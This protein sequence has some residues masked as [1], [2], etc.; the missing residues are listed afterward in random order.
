MS[1]LR[2]IQ[3]AA[4]TSNVPISNLLRKC[5]ILAS[6]L[7]YTN[8]AEWVDEELGGYSDIDRLPEYRILRVNSKGHFFGAFGQELKNADIPLLAIDEKFREDLQYSYLMQPVIALEVLAGDSESGVVH[9]AWPPDLVAYVGKD[10]YE[11]M[12]C[13]QAWKVIPVVAIISAI[14]QVRNRVLNFVL[15]I[16]SRAPD[17]GESE[18]GQRPIPKKE[19]DKIFNTYIRR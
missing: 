7:D 8:L 5:K 3:S 16:E 1:L 18:S 2:E 9:E 4:T 10:I 6:R 19:V 17:A 11:N 14:D 13:L 15:E 12:N